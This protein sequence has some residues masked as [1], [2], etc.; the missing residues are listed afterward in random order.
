MTSANVIRHGKRWIVGLIGRIGIAGAV[1]IV[2]LFIF[3][4]FSAEFGE[5]GGGLPH[6]DLEVLRYLRVHRIGWLFHLAY[7]VS[8]SFRPL[9]QG[10]IVLLATGVFLLRRR[11][12]AAVTLLTG[13]VG[14][15]LVIASLKALFGR[16]RPEEIFAPL[17]YSFPSGHTF[18]AVTILGI[19]GYFLAQEVASRFRVFVWGAAGLGMFVVGWSRIYLGEHYPTDV[20]AGFMSGFCW[21]YVCLLSAKYVS[22][23]AT[24]ATKT[25]AN[26]HNL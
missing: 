16:P 12:C 20:G 3:A 10:I 6:F 13:V 15:G 25:K 2:A 18:G 7:R 23:S 4:R 17:G 1:A 9:G 22:S 24:D 11:Q 19:A 21:V 14:G 26:T 8:W 5:Q